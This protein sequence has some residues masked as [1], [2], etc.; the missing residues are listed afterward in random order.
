MKKETK[1]HLG[2]AELQ[3][4]Q[5]LYTATC[6]SALLSGAKPSRETSLLRDVRDMAYSWLLVSGVPIKLSVH[7]HFEREPAIIQR[8]I[9]VESCLFGPGS[10]FTGENMWVAYES[11]F[12]YSQTHG[13]NKVGFVL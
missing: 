3:Q 8:H 6:I 5:L 10:S 13:F 12:V 7:K 11:S 1:K 2:L 4:L 9:I